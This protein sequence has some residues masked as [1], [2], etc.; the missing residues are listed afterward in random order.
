MVLRW[1]SAPSST[2]C[3]KPPVLKRAS[4]WLS[5]SSILPPLMSLLRSRSSVR[6]SALNTGRAGRPV[7]RLAVKLV[8][9][10]L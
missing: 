9:D 10:V 5:I 3:S 7:S 1:K 6:W 8:Y 2:V 4:A